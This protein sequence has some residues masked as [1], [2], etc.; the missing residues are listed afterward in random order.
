MGTVLA[1]A[2]GGAIGSLLRYFISR[3]L[4]GKLGI[5]FPVGTLTVNLIG[6]LFIG[7]AFSYLVEKL[8]ISAETRAFFITGLAGGFTTFS[9][10]SYESLNLM[11]NGE[12]VKFLLYLLGTNILCLFLT[13]LGY[14]LGR[15]L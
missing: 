3:F 4:Q 7:F 13:F 15:M 12:Y 11:L 2:L 10:F 14:N 9:T 8:N 6:S 1:I 5:D